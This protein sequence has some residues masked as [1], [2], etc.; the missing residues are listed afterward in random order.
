M[1]AALLAADLQMDRG[2]QQA[3]AILGELLSLRYSEQALENADWERREKEWEAS[4]DGSSSDRVIAP[5]E[6]E[7]AWRLMRE[8]AKILYPGAF[9]GDDE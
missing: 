5:T 8:A 9:S 4:G 3:V 7:L 1:R 6:Q 2:A